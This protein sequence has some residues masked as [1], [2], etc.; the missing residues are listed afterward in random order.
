MFVSADSYT[1]TDQ[2]ADYREIAL[3]FS[4]STHHSFEGEYVEGM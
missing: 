3:R 2:M 4:A 1:H